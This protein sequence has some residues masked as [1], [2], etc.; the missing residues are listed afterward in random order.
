MSSNFKETVLVPWE[1]ALRARY[2]ETVEVT[3]DD[4]QIILKKGFSTVYIKADTI[5]NGPNAFAVFTR[6]N[7]RI[8]GFLGLSPNYHTEHLIQQLD[9][10]FVMARYM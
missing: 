4:N 5:E 2:K 3:L 10:C 9:G 6:S 7:K 8:Q 1:N